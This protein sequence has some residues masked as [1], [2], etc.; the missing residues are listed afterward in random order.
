MDERLLRFFVAVYE[1]K[2]ISRAAE[3]CFVS[4]PNI[5]NGIKNIEELLGKELFVR[6]KKGVTIKEEGHQLYPIAKRILGEL[7]EIPE[8]FKQKDFKQK[9]IL[10]VADSLPQ[11]LKKKFFLQ[12]DEEVSNIEW[13]IRAIGRDC[14]LN[15]LVREWKFEEHL[16]LPLWKEDYVLC[17]PDHHP[18][19]DK[20][21]IEITDLK[22]EPFIHC[23]PCEAHQQS[24]SILNDLGGKWK[25]VANCAT[26][27]DV[28][29]LLVSGLGITFLPESFVREW[30]GFQIKKYKGPVS[31]REVGLSY[32]KD[33]LSNPAV[34]EI[35]KLFSNNN[36]INTTE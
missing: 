4:Q 8:L 15:L 13:D 35:V 10:G 29:T 31:Y 34:A 22:G 36:Q 14:D 18:L 3:K 21:E 23:P 16:F 27:N 28:L 1:E 25:T 33:S 2:N 24:L 12:I 19:C 6:H 11:S 5:S 17:I 7:N 20:D 32:P 26:K 9:V 30:N